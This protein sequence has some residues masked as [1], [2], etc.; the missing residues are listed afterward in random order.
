M[1]KQQFAHEHV[2]LLMMYHLFLCIYVFNSFT[3]FFN[4]APIG[5]IFK[6]LKTKWESFF[7]L[8]FFVFCFFCFFFGGG[9]VVMNPNIVRALLIWTTNKNQ[10]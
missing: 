7:F 4:T 8:F 2:F 3:D 6:Y 5:L 10:R 1:L 9:V